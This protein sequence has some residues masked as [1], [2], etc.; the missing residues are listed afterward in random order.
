MLLKLTK[1]KPLTYVKGFL[2]RNTFQTFA[3][4]INISTMQY[5]FYLFIIITA[6][7]C[8][9]YVPPTG[10]TKDSLAPKLIN[11]IPENKKTNFQNREIELVFDELVDITGLRQE[12]LVVPEIEG[13]FEIKQKTGNSIKMIFDKKLKE[14]TTYTF[15]FRNGIKDLNE[16]NE[17]KNL[18][19]IF[20]TGKEI[21]SLGIEGNV[22]NLFTNQGVLDAL[23]GIYEL[24][25][26]L[27][28]RKVKPNYFIKTDSSGNFKFEN[29][30]SAKYRLYSFSDKNNNLKFD[31][32]NEMI[33]F[34]KDTIDLKKNYSEINLSLYEANTIKPKVLRGIA[35]SDEFTVMYD[36][37]IKK[38]NINF[39]DNNDSLAYDVSY[40]QIRFFN[41]NSKT[42]TIKVNITATDSAGV[43][44]N[45]LQKIKF[46][47]PE[48][49]R[50]VKSEPFEFKIET[51]N[52]EDVEMD[53]ALMIKFDYPIIKYEI[54]KIKILSDTIKQENLTEK[55]LIWNIY[56]NELKIN[57]KVSAI[58][59]VKTVFEKG[60]FVNIKNDSSTT[61]KLLNPILL[62]ENY[63]LL[64][65]RIEGGKESKIIQLIDENYKVI[66]EQTVRDKFSF[67]HV[68]PNIY[69]IRII[70]DL[71]ENAQWDYGDVDKNILPE[72]IFITKEPI[73][74]KENFELR[75]QVIKIK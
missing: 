22:K 26:T 44:M 65:G 42:D 57:K 28:F 60:A 61:L 18:K 58:K 27:N 34:L 31:E 72:P 7:G 37:N 8:A 62:E 48:K 73:R 75:D 12:L 36:K 67:I 19:L 71:N 74:I 10:G 59:L 17:S 51:K 20:S 25:D 39:I 3:Q 69:L 38:F 46:R 35:K 13:A 30:R 11:S 68:K 40:K 66:K 41:I 9:Q 47:E 53:M 1:F 29:I 6:W 50:N 63:G 33:S 4:I 2:F 5:I 15:N 14:N 49:K 43:S 56:K 64:E 70:S 52:G 24:S 21:D 23:V 55:D 32:K 45:H 54:D 16:R